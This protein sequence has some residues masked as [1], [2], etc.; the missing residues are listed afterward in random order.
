MRYSKKPTL[1]PAYAQCLTESL[2]VRQSAARL[3]L[4]VSV[5]FRWRHALLGEVD[6]RDDTSLRG[7][8]ELIDLWFAF[9]EKGKRHLNRPPRA[10]GV[11]DRFRFRGKSVRV[12]VA[13]DRSG[14][15][16]T[17]LAWTER[18]SA[19]NLIGVLERRIKEA[20]VLLAAQGRLGAVSRFARRIGGTFHNIRRPGAGVDPAR[21][22]LRTV[23]GYAARFRQWLDRFRGVATRYLNN[24]LGWHRF[25]ACQPMS[26]DVFME[27]PVGRWLPP[28]PSPT[29]PANTARRPGA[30]AS[31]SRPAPDPR[32]IL[33]ALPG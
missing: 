33:D 8:I 28:S 9:S 10:H 22:H 24:Y 17:K 19:H 2:T 32:P 7:W 13:C 21:C 30:A 27:W 18:V 14:G 5:A 23:I 16:V 6:Q 1:W 25:L 12:I 31:L 15:V 4:S 20:P 11:R 3:N 29:I 26:A